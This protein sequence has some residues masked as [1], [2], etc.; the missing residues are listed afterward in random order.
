MEEINVIHNIKDDMIIE[1]LNKD[2][3]VKLMSKL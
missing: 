3:N 2:I 1:Q